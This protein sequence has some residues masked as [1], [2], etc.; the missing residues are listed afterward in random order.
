MTVTNNMY[1]LWV[2]IYNEKYR[3]VRLTLCS[4]LLWESAKKYY[5]QELIHGSNFTS[6][7]PLEITNKNSNAT[8]K[9]H[10]LIW[11]RQRNQRDPT[12]ENFTAA[13][14]MPPFKKVETTEAT[15]ARCILRLGKTNN[16]VAWK[17]ELKFT[18]GAQYG[19]RYTYTLHLYCA[20]IIMMQLTAFLFNLCRVPKIHTSLV[21]SS[22]NY[23]VILRL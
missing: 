3:L 20:L 10:F 2:K 5:Q 6:L 7:G 21:M 13:L 16:V 12:W 17:E 1:E 15:A 22:F 23:G 14:Q 19:I 18:V 8:E 9:N 4:C 11:A